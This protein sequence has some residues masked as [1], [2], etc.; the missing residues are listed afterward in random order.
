MRISHTESSSC[1]AQTKFN[2]HRFPNNGSTSIL[3]PMIVQIMNP[4]LSV[5]PVFFSHMCTSTT[6]RTVCKAVDQ[7]GQSHH[8][9]VFIS[10]FSNGLGQ[11]GRR[12]VW[13]DASLIPQIETVQD[14]L[15]RPSR[16][17]DLG[18]FT[19]EGRTVFTDQPKTMIAS[20]EV[21]NL[22]KK[23]V[24]AQ[25]SIRPAVWSIARICGVCSHSV[26]L[27]IRDV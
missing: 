5:Y 3:H 18:G 16:G 10:L 25:S 27:T 1:Q 7:H 26:R 9:L 15:R 8:F 11:T 22:E 23:A 17:N 20:P 12:I 19:A 13:S 14:R 24:P 21:S 4:S 6:W 2:Q